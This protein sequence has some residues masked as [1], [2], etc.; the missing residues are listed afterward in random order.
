MD[1]N[2]P[3]RPPSLAVW[4]PTHLHNNQACSVVPPQL[5]PNN[6]SNKRHFFRNSNPK[7]NQH[8][9]LGLPLLLSR[10]CRRARLRWACL[11]INRRQDSNSLPRSSK[12]LSRVRSLGSLKLSLHKT[13]HLFLVNKLSSPRPQVYSANNPSS[14]PVSFLSNQLKGDLLNNPNKPSNQTSNS[15]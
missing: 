11:G 13:R 2:S 4:L 12:L 3:S 1:S 15:R 7:L 5:N 14:S 8:P 10:L 6:N 9:F